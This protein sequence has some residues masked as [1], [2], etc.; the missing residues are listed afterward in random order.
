MEN[1][2]K[3][4]NLCEL[5]PKIAYETS[6][7]AS[8]KPLI[9]SRSMRVL[10]AGGGSGGSAT[11][12]LAVAEV[13]RARDPAL[14]MLYIGTSAGPERALVEAAGI[15]F[16]TVPAG[17]LRRYF[18]LQNVLDVGNVGVGVMRSI[19]VVRR[20]RPD[21]AFGA[22]GFACVPPLWAARLSGVPVH[23]HQQD[24]IPGL[25][26]KLLTPAATS[27]SVTF[28]Q[29]QRHF[30]AS[31]TTVTGNPVRRLVLEGDRSRFFDQ[32]GLDADIPLVLITG[33]GTGALRLNQLV[34]EASGHLVE[35]VQVMHLTGQGRGVEVPFQSARY[36]QKA[37][38]VEEMA[39][40]LQAACVIVSRAGLGT[41]SE[42]GALALPAIVIPM[43]RSHQQANA[44]A[45]AAG[46][47]ALVMDEDGLTP[48][49]LARETLGLVA[50]A[51]RRTALGEAARRMLPLDA[52]ERVADQIKAIAKQA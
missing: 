14:Q 15:P 40:V 33:G 9:E 44:R 47:A 20:F 5:S 18:D 29:S 52:A 7:G 36:V 8:N 1:L 46:G 38:L 4:I 25:A 50:D 23:I 27:I 10:L 2:P 42:I 21:V 26:N 13:L 48:A 12:V 51:T 24:A 34:A 49:M 41:L 32:F 37:F 30:P 35:Q 43:P 16:H 31:R 3:S 11:P 39:D 6:A 22:G 28:S 19:D 45:F 17:K